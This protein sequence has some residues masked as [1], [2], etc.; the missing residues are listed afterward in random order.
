MHKD[1][2]SQNAEEQ[3]SGRKSEFA[4]CCE[5][6]SES[7]GVCGGGTELDMKEMMKAGPCGRVLKRHRVAVYVTLTGI[8]LGVLTLQAGWLLGVIAFF[9]TL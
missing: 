6:S 8:G 2:N 4:S 5:G 3:T 7:P 1:A 9:R